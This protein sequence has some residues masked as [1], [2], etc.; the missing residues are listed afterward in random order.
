MFR[1]NLTIPQLEDEVAVYSDGSK[2]GPDCGSGFFMCWRDQTRF[3]VSYNGQKYT[4]FLSEIRAISLALDR[5][6]WEKLPNTAVNNYSDSQSAIAGILNSKSN[7]KA[8][9]EC[10]TKL[11]KLDKLYKWSLTWVKAHAGLKGNEQADKLAK[12]GTQF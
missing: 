5:L 6:I 2:L 10:W 1:N 7:S 12:K 8:V 9:Q 4:V 3:G 11:S